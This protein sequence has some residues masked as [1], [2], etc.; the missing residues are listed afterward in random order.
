MN[1]KNYF[2]EDDTMTKY[3]YMGL[4]MVMSILPAYG[5]SNVLQNPGFENGTDGWEARGCKIEA[6]TTPVH[7]GSGAVKATERKDTWQ[8][9][10]QSLIG[11]VEN[12]KTYKLSG[13]VRLDN[14]DKDNITL[15]VESEDDNPVKYGNIETLTCSNSDWTELSGTFTP[16]PSGEWKTL[17]IYFEG[18]AENINFFVDDV[19][20]TE[21]TAPAAEPNKPAKVAPKAE[22]NT[23][24]KAEVAASSED[25]NAPKKADPNASKA[26]PNA[27][28][29]SAKKKHT[30]K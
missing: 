8:G 1:F 4:L 24:Q 19:S 11:K 29:K 12:G 21:V 30:A 25:P 9:I 14:S 20:V 15:S 2:C 10:K 6:V 13:W 26:D 16:S 22:P 3:L 27:S 5:D 7:S 28:A 17:D 23:T 18:P